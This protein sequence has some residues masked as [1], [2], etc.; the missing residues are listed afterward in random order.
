MSSLGRV[1]KARSLRPRVLG[2]TTHL[3]TLLTQC[4]WDFYGLPHA[5][6]VGGELSLGPLAPLWRMVC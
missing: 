5:G 3:E 1:W 6:M 4:Y 2:C